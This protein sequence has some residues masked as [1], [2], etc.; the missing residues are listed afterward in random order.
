MTPTPAAE[1][2]ALLETPPHLSDAVRP[3]AE[4][5]A[6]ADAV[7]YPLLGRRAKVQRALDAL[8]KG[9]GPT[10]ERLRFEEQLADLDAQIADAEAEQCA[11]REAFTQAR[12]AES[13]RRLEEHGDAGDHLS[14]T[15]S[16]D[17]VPGDVGASATAGAE[18]GGGMICSANISATFAAKS[19]RV[20]GVGGAPGALSCWRTCR[21]RERWECDI[22]LGP[23][24]PGF[25][26]RRP[27]W[28]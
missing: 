5:V 4:R 28:T 6:A 26:S 9:H 7:L 18:G 2:P 17:D 3:V 25:K 23:E 20:A 13:R 1:L 27:D 12:V 15:R 11:A 19:A 14:A 16:R 22:G 8:V 21:T 10:T 24:G